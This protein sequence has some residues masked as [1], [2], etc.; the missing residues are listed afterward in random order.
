MVAVAITVAVLFVVRVVISSILPSRPV[1]LPL[2]RI[3]AVPVEDVA[4]ESSH[5]VGDLDVSH[6]CAVLIFWVIGGI[7]AGMFVDRARSERSGRLAAAPRLGIDVGRHHGRVEGVDWGT[8]RP[9]IQAG[10][11]Q[12]MPDSG[13]SKKDLRLVCVCVYLGGGSMGEVGLGARFKSRRKV[14]GLME[15]WNFRRWR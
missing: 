6:V 11:G 8:V 12:P 2:C 3:I 10:H 1:A 4:E 15:G 13:F 14:E 7:E 5:L 9:T